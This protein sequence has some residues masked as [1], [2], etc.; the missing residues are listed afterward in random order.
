MASITV[1]YIHVP[2]AEGYGKWREL[3]DVN[4]L[5]RAEED[6]GDVFCLWQTLMIAAMLRR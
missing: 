4:A 2:R 6:D 5:Q 3:G 1:V